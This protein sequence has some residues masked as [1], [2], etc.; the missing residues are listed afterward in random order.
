M[1]S[2]T[3][4]GVGAENGMQTEVT[5]FALHLELTSFQKNKQDAGDENAQGLLE[6][7]IAISQ[8]LLRGRYFV[9]PSRQSI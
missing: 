9:H 4:I 5:K 8:G 3:E 2:Q 6:G 7:R 1:W